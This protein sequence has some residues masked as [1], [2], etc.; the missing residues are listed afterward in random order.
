[1][2]KNPRRF[3][4]PARISVLILFFLPPVLPAA[5]AAR[6][7]D[8]SPHAKAELVA[9][10]DAVA[11]GES[12]W[13]GLHFVLE[14][15]WHTY[16]QN[17][18]DSGEP[19]RVQWK[20][21]A[22]FHAGP[23]EWPAPQRLGS[24]TVVDFGYSGELLLMIPLAIPASA[25]PGAR[26]NLLATAKWLVCREICIPD[27]AQSLTLNIAHPSHTP[28]SASGKLC[29][30]SSGNSSPPPRHPTGA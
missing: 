12:A 20:L 25:V 26:E 2:E 28:L 22:G 23:I 24:A 8:H 13:L 18:G 27:Q 30:R 14:P 9:E 10:R 17:P 11:P 16:W 7:E 29:L 3:R 15:G 4:N 6:A 1:M 19:P 5:A 21:P